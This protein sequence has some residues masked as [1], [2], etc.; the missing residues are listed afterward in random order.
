[1]E[2]N[3]NLTNKENPHQPNSLISIIALSVAVIGIVIAVI[4]LVLGGKD[5]ET[6][7]ISISDDGY[8]VINGEKTNVKA[9][10]KEP[11]ITNENPQGLDFYLKDDGTYIVSIGKAKYLSKV[12][13]PATY[14]GK[15]VTEI[16][17][18]GFS[19]YPTNETFPLKE[20]VIP[21]SVTSIGG[22]AF[23]KCSSLTSVVIGNGVTSIGYSAFSDCS[24]LTSIVIP[25]SVTSIGNRAFSPCS[26]L[27]DVYYT[28][29]ES[30]WSSILIGYVNSALDNATKHYNYVP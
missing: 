6:P 19:G 4:A 3:T 23:Y 30:Q 21:D 12:V 13:I 1:M 22:G 20:I 25:D 17:R 27:T 24:S 16:A 14:C 9:E 28:G 7:T 15:S 11:E 29:S 18:Y 5:G 26:S 8:W 10:V 2:E